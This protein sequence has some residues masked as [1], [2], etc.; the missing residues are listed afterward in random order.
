MDLARR[1]E[2]GPEYPT[3][4]RPQGSKEGQQAFLAGDGQGLSKRLAEAGIWQG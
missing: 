1:M 4:L 2:K 3:F